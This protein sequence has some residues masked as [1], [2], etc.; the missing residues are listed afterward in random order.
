MAR[1]LNTFV[2]EESAAA[3]LPLPYFPVYAQDYYGQCGEDLMVSA[4]LRAI[5]LRFALDLTKEQYLEVGG[6]H[7]IATSATYLLHR[8]LGMRGVIVEA[9]PQLLEDLRRVRPHDTIVYG[10]VQTSDARTVQLSISNASELSSLD[11][12][13]VLEWDEGKVGEREQIEV[14][15]LR[16]NELIATQLEGRAPLFLSVDTEGTDLDI[17]RDLDL[18]RYRPGLIQIE[19]SDQFI[20]NNSHRMVEVLASSGYVLLIRTDV[21]LIFMDTGLLGLPGQRAGIGELG[22]E[23]ALQKLQVE[24]KS[25]H[26]QLEL[27]REAPAALD[28]SRREADALRQELEATRNRTATAASELDAARLQSASLQSHLDAARLQSASLQSDL[29]AARLQS[30]SLQ[31]DLDAARQE[32]NA[33]RADVNAAR[34]GLDTAHAELDALRAQLEAAL[35][36]VA[37]QSAA[38][39]ELREAIEIARSEAGASQQELATVRRVADELTATMPSIESAL[40]ESRRQS[41]TLAAELTTARNECV[42]LQ[43]QVDLMTGSKSWRWTAPMRWAI[44][45]TALRNP[46]E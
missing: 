17:I 19:P 8:L 3:G 25:L 10:A 14:P 13:F 36:E 1:R 40:D 35:R 32:S 27:S 6:N 38:A 12:R 46:R 34:H 33:L 29:D 4:L 15:A 18:G 30:A 42:A 31:S 21:N 2:Y 45:V 9:N 16:I 24:L 26:Q 7:P 22:P 23:V 44:K 41:D 43:A 28:A 20:E 39:Q 5:A 11:R 37:A